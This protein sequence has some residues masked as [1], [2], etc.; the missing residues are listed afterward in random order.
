MTTNF[1]FQLGLNLTCALLGCTVFQPTGVS[2]Q[3]ASG[4]SAAC[5]NELPSVL[6]TLEQE[7]GF[8]TTAAR[9]INDQGVMV[10][11]ASVRKGL[12]S[13]SNVDAPVRW[14]HR[15]QRSRLS[16]QPSGLI[17]GN[18]AIFF[19]DASSTG[20]AVNNQGQAVGTS[21]AKAVLYEQG[22]Q[23][24]LNDP[25]RTSTA[26]SINN[27]SLVVGASSFEGTSLRAALFTN[28]GV[29]D[30][31]VLSGG[32]QS[33]ANS[34]NDQGVVVGSSAYI[35]QFG[36]LR[37]NRA[38]IFS[39]NGT[40]RSL[41]GLSSSDTNSAA[42]AIN[43]QNQIVGAATFNV[44]SSSDR[45]ILYQDG[46]V[47]DLGSLPGNSS[48]IALS[49]NDRGEVVG[50]AGNHIFLN[51]RGEVVETL[52]DRAFLYRQGKLIDLNDLVPANSLW[53][54]RQA[55]GINNLGEIVGDGTLNGAARSFL[56]TK[57]CLQ[58]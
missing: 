43:N 51:N 15:G 58:K 20:L 52:L 21:N 57:P 24:S 19:G 38:V 53:V 46:T 10:G 16:P 28:N 37:Q 26:L 18:L 41:N 32:G 54:L 49:I 50:A 13:N 14:N 4:V 12:F 45:A 40:V 48:S 34:I 23:R 29:I 42:I 2:A 39:K 25:S 3:T 55:H 35:D 11:F 1:S 36:Q 17:F 7:P 47:L 44:P 5:V 27:S 9:G 56:L 8:P 22:A 33:R 30:L 6:I 31:G